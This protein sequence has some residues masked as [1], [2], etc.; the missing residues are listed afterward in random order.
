MSL[1]LRV[2]YLLAVVLTGPVRTI[3][4]GSSRAN[5]VQPLDIPDA[6]NVDLT[7]DDAVSEPEEQNYLP[8][9]T[10]MLGEHKLLCGDAMKDLN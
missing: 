7:D 1:S 5:R 3:R 4:W 9:V 2:S 8:R 6:N 10:C